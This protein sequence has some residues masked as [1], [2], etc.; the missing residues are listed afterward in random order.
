[1]G[2]GYAAQCSWLGGGFLYQGL[3]GSEFI[4]E[5]DFESMG[6]PESYN[7]VYSGLCDRQRQLDTDNYSRHNDGVADT[8]RLC[9]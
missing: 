9:E 1:M 2:A 8:F 5:Q 3:K 6:V 7:V 4:E